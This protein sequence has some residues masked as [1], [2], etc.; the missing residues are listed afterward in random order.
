[1]NYTQFTKC[2]LYRPIC[3]HSGEYPFFPHFFFLGGGCGVRGEPHFGLPI[4]L[5]G[6]LNSTS[7]L[8]SKFLILK[9]TIMQIFQIF[10]YNACHVSSKQDNLF[11]P[12][13][14]SEITT[15][16][17]L[18]VVIG[19]WLLPSPSKTYQFWPMIKIPMKEKNRRE[20]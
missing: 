4:P 17:S 6:T 8:C 9:E 3:R 7:P 2:N 1:M 13:I 12:M 14:L 15:V 11:F 18:S 16:D 20:K 19:V 5:Y 10:E